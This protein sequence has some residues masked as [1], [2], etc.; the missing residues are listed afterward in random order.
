M[1]N[2]LATLNGLTGRSCL[3]I[4]TVGPVLLYLHMHAGFLDFTIHVQCFTQVA[5]TFNAVVF[6]CIE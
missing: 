4:S 2:N 5:L 6:I 3:Y 1:A